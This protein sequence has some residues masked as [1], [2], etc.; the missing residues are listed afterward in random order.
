MATQHAHNTPCN[1]SPEVD[2]DCTTGGT[3]SSQGGM[4]VAQS[5]NNIIK[6]SLSKT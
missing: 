5:E 2:D 1:I 4:G 6:Y 3:G